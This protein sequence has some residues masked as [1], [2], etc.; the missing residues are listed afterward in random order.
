MSDAVSASDQAAVDNAP[1]RGR[2]A[3]RELA[4]FAL[5][6]ALA[7]LLTWPLAAV[8]DTAVSDAGD[9]LLNTFI[10]DWVCHS[11][12]HAPAQLFQAPIFHPAKHTLALSENMIG[13]ALF[14]LPLHLGGAS[15]LFIYNFAVLLG[16]AFS[17]YGA[18]VLARLVSGSMVGGI[19]AGILYGFVPFRFDHLSHIQII[20]G[21]WL[22]LLL[23]ALLAFWRKPT[24]MRAGL[25]T[26]AF[27]MNGLTNIHWLLFG[28]FALGVVILF[29]AISGERK[30]RQQWIRLATA[31][32][33]GGLILIPVLLPY[34]TVSKFYEFRRHYREVEGGSASLHDWLMAPP[35]NIIY[36]SLGN[37]I[38]H[39]SERTLFPGLTVLL[40]TG[41]AILLMP[42]SGDRNHESRAAPEGHAKLLRALD[43]LAVLA[44]V[45]LYVGMA[46]EDMA[47][48]PGNPIMHLGTAAVPAVILIAA[49]VARLSIRFPLALGGDEGRSLRTAIR[50]SR[51][52][53]EHWAAALWIAIGFLGSLG[54]NSFLHPFLYRTVSAFHSLRVPARWAAIAYVGLAVWAAAGVALLLQ[55]RKGW[56]RIVMAAV[57]LL[58]A[59][60]D[61]RQ[62]TRLHHV[63]SDPLPVHRWMAGTL[64]GPALELP[65]T[66]YE[67]EYRYM[68]GATTHR[69]PIFNGLSGFEP[70]LHRKL[71]TM[72][73]ENEF[74]DRFTALLEQ[75]GCALVI[76]HPDWM[77]PDQIASSFAWLRANLATGR[78]AFVRRF[79]HD[80]SGDWVFALTRVARSW[81]SWRAPEVP[82]A[83]GYLPS[84]NVRRLLDSAGATYSDST[85]GRAES[86]RV[87]DEVTG[88]LRVQGWALS[89]HGVDR[90][91][92]RLHSGTKR[93]VA[94]PY[95]R[96]DVAAIHPWYGKTT[97]PGFTLT[98]DKRPRG[99]P[100]I[101]DVQVEIIDGLGRSTR[102]PD[103]PI[104]WND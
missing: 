42:R 63:P 11:L 3:L 59:F 88:P 24:R 19:V 8:M 95:D 61:V 52:S 37:A 68:L 96:P 16:F 39:R 51:F 102:L 7:I 41:A 49:L 92:V 38:D 94:Q 89:P 14:C 33:I 93:Y 71:R 2:V 104:T 12:T 74:D 70:P 45:A 36:G 100:R 34:R 30:P 47:L 60:A 31:L 23:A 13:V 25:L 81:E 103:V 69:V 6:A 65:M 5:Y 58:A 15:P 72:T 85:F 1:H 90:V 32:V 67:V 76:V 40:L 9:P 82:D 18:Y 21:G 66:G 91:V 29:F 57:L 28:S 73:M 77:K 55:R 75:N 97:Q 86:P 78:L 17:A 4:V 44:A 48:P 20:W 99:V 64:P 27:V 101:T 46:A 50:A 35:N 87:H 84:Q 22:P 54:M 62:R 10:I 26:G 43:T 80:L 83:A 56:R 53:T 79:D 98:L